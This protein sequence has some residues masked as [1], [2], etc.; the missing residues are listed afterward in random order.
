ME[1]HSTPPL[2]PEQY[3]VLATLRISTLRRELEE[4]A[5]MGYRVVAAAS[6]GE[7]CIVMTKDPV[8][9]KRD[10]LLLADNNTDTLRQEIKKAVQNGYLPMPS[11]VIH[12]GDL[13]WNEPKTG[14]VLE[15]AT[16]HGSHEYLF[17]EFELD[18]AG[19]LQEASKTDGLVT[20]DQS[21]LVEIVS[22]AQKDGYHLVS[23]VA[24]MAIFTKGKE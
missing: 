12:T 8:D 1:K 22:K 18:L 20:I 17:E 3:L 14:V 24:G 4:A 7:H 13:F 5:A 11:A 21:H 16:T 23:R 19:A 15:K 2:S 10:Y 9:E 6:N